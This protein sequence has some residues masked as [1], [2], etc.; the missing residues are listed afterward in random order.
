M[1][2]FRLNNAVDLYNDGTKLI[3]ITYLG[4]DIAA[5]SINFIRISHVA[6]KGNL[7]K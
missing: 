4:G 1:E 7:G 3:S 6:I 2:E 5:D